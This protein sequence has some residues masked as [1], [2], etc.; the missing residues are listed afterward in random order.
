MLFIC[1]ALTDVGLASS[2][3]LL[4][5]TLLWT[6]TRRFSLSPHFLFS[7]A[8]AQE[9]NCW[10][11]GPFVLLCEEPSDCFPQKLRP[12]LGFKHPGKGQQAEKRGAGFHRPTATAGF[13]TESDFQTADQRARG[14]SGEATRGSPKPLPR[15][16]SPSTMSSLLLPRACQPLSGQ[17]QASVF[18]GQ[19]GTHR[20]LGKSPCGLSPQHVLRPGRS[21]DTQSP[22]P[23]R[24]T[25]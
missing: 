19:L 15:P 10:V 24:P 3:W 4:G 5:I 25:R 1:S 22:W 13:K 2:F 8:G 21:G 18:P 16:W 12:L 14:G 23:A 11:T 7:G 17:K 9:R 20:Q 6:H